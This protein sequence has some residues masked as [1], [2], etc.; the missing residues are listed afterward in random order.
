[1]ALKSSRGHVGRSF[2]G[3]FDLESKILV[4]GRFGMVL[5]RFGAGFGRFLT[6]LG[7]FLAGAGPVWAGFG[8]E[9]KISAPRGGYNITIAAVVAPSSKTKTKL[10][11]GCLSA[12]GEHD[13]LCFSSLLFRASF[14]PKLAPRPR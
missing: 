11:N 8:P 10:L 2:H 7:R 14:W 3:G 1:M 5:G 13:H 6:G 12:P 9:S 4:L